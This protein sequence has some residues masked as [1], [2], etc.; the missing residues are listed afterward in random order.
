MPD[1]KAGYNLIRQRRDGGAGRRGAS[2]RG[3]G[4]EDLVQWSHVQWE[5]QRAARSKTK[6]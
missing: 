1:L 6:E 5:Q 4:A 3:S 2:A